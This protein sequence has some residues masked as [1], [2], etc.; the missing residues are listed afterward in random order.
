MAVRRCTAVGN[1]SS[2]GTPQKYAFAGKTVARLSDD[3]LSTDVHTR[4]FIAF[5]NTTGLHT[6]KILHDM[7]TVLGNLGRDDDALE[8]FEQ[9]LAGRENVIGKDH[10]ATKATRDCITALKQKLEG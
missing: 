1:K 8:R 2:D 9:V 4:N 7:A 5:V 3:L 6:R 10:P